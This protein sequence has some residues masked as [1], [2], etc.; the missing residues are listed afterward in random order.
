[1][2]SALAVG[3]V[4][5]WRRCRIVSCATFMLLKLRLFLQVVNVVLVSYVIS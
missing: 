5:N 2:S 1:M 4:G 3:F